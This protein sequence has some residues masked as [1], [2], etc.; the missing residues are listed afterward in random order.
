MLAAVFERYGPPEVVHLAE[1][2]IPEPVPA[3]GAVLPTPPSLS[4][5]V[6]MPLTRL[7]RRRRAAI[8]FT[9]LLPTERKR[10]DLRQLGGLVARGE[11]AP[12]IDR[13]VPF[14]RIAEAHARVDTRRKVGAVVVAIA[15][16]GR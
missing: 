13:V 2:S 10:D 15:G 14:E 16:A 4:A 5:L 6:L 1:R 12:V 9:G 11:F 3:D 8:S 7:L